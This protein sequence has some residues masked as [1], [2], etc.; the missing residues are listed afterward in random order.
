M[1]G[2]GDNEAA[3]REWQARTGRNVR[4]LDL[5]ASSPAKRQRQPQLIRQQQ[6]DK[7]NR[8][9]QAFEAEVLCVRQLRGELV[10]YYEH[11]AIPL[12]LANGLKYN[13]DY[14]AIEINPAGGVRLVFFEVK[15]EQRQGRVRARDDAV[16]KIKQAA[17]KFTHF[18]F[19]LVWK[20]PAT[21]E[22]LEQEVKA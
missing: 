7:R 9:E 13:P 1:K 10:T 2:F 20:N 17:A 12:R 5:P 3:V 8:A 11:E 6:S 15:G 14:P 22:W 21:G 16:V 18:R 19:V 4:G